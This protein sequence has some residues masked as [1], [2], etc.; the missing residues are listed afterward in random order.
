[1]SKET[2]VSRATPPMPGDTSL[3][4]PGCEHT[5]PAE[6]AERR[7]EAH[8]GRVRNAPTNCRGTGTARRPDLGG[9]VE[10]GTA[11]AWKRDSRSGM[12]I[13]L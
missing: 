5:G 11:T 10:R 9:L 4:G 12:S 2:T 1:M 7:A 6:Q 8:Q 3:A 13:D